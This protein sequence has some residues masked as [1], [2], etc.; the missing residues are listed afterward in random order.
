MTRRR[1]G[2][3]GMTP[4]AA[5]WRQ[6]R[7]QGNRPGRH[8]G[9]RCR[10]RRWHRGRQRGR[11]GSCRRGFRRNRYRLRRGNGSWGGSWRGTGRWSRLGRRPGCW[12]WCRGRT[13]SW[14]R[15]RRRDRLRAGR[16]MRSR[17]GRGQGDIRCGRVTP[18]TAPAISRRKFPRREVGARRRVR[19]RP[20]RQSDLDQFGIQALPV[21]LA[22][23]AVHRLARPRSAYLDRHLRAQNAPR[24]VRA[25]FI[26]RLD[27]QYR[28]RDPMQTNGHVPGIQPCDELVTRVDADDSPGEVALPRPP[29][30][31]GEK[32]GSQQKRD[33]E[34]PDNP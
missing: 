28:A 22:H 10:Q 13:R 18:N 20:G 33:G 4:V 21:T 2:K 3:R 27:G 32:P 31:R 15:C 1:L 19:A 8:S 25:R 12:G 17:R 16:W 6:S 7:I 23:F 5:Y 24:R 30:P 11:G 34:R 14:S 9:G 26:A 29:D